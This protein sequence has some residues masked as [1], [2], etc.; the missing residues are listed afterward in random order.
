MLSCGRTSPT[1]ATV[2]RIGWV[3]V[4]VG[5]GSGSG[6]AGGSVVVVVWEAEAVVGTTTVGGTVTVV[7][8]S[9]RELGRASSAGQKIKGVHEGNHRKSGSHG[10][11][12]VSHRRDLMSASADPSSGRRGTSP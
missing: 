6:S 7:C 4:V 3:V 1:A 2:M 10:L 11:Q 9:S 5:S 8:A 12:R